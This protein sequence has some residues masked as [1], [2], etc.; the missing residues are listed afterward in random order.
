MLKAQN[1]PISQYPISSHF[2][3]AAL[4]KLLDKT[5]CFVVLLVSV[6]LQRRSTHNLHH[7]HST[8]TRQRL[9]NNI[10][11]P[12]LHTFQSVQTIYHPLSFCLTVNNTRYVVTSPLG[13]SEVTTEDMNH[14]AS[15]ASTH[16][17][18]LSEIMKLT[19]ISRYGRLHK[20]TKGV[21]SS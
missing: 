15:A 4:N 12:A 16:L 21:R 1:A 6:S 8:A 9:F 19:F 3:A 5:F 18:K 11:L 7:I 2:L 13:G 17:L 10:F 20:K 14:N